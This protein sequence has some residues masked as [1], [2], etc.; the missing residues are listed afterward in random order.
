MIATEPAGEKASRVI[1]NFR[2]TKEFGY[3]YSK[4]RYVVGPTGDV[5][6]VGMTF[7]L[8]Y[9]YPRPIS[10]LPAEELE[11]SA[12][13]GDG[14]K[15]G[16]EFTPKDID[17]LMEA[18][19]IME[20]TPGSPQPA[21]TAS[22]G[23]H[24]SPSIAAIKMEKVPLQ[25]THLKAETVALPPPKPWQDRPRHDCFD[26]TCDDCYVPV[27]HAWRDRVIVDGKAPEHRHAPLLSLRACNCSACPH[28]IREGA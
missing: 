15:Q 23:E 20:E 6:P 28:P 26:C 5:C 14:N 9:I 19:A 7:N 22:Q 4:D 27:T 24:Q 11:Y 17:D 21:N 13:D 18:G 12:V 3:D 2:V 8:T 25:Q 16:V 10:G 1:K